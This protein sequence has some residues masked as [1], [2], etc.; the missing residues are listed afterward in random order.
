MK[1]QMVEES[2]PCGLNFKALCHAEKEMYSQRFA[3]LRTNYNSNL[4]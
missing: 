1:L 3:N 4:D 2:I